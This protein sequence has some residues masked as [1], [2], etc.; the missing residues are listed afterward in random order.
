MPPDRNDLLHWILPYAPARF[1][2]CVRSL[3][4]AS[5]FVASRQE[6]STFRPR[7]VCCVSVESGWRAGP[8]YDGFLVGEGAF[9]VFTVHLRAPSA[10]DDPSCGRAIVA[11]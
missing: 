9:T 5:A 4:A 11:S 1:M 6:S 3:W 10:A 2:C 8:G 7:L